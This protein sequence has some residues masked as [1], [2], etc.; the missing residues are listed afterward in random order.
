MKK[1][2]LFAAAGTV[3]M[4]LT[5]QAMAQFTSSCNFRY[6]GRA[7][8]P[9]GVQVALMNGS[10]KPGM[11]CTESRNAGASVTSGHVRILGVKLVQR[12]KK[13]SVTVGRN[14]LKY[15]P[16][17][18][19]NDEFVVRYHLSNSHGSGYRFFHYRLKAR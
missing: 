8:K 13:G 1:L 12:P 15:T 4:I 10:Y 6:A 17:G 3:A 18:T 7:D 5:T 14:S 16:T 2:A 9:N 19:G 11:P